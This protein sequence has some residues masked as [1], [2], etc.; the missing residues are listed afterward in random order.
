MKEGDMVSKSVC[1][2]TF[3]LPEILVGNG[4]SSVSMYRGNFKVREKKVSWIPLN[5][6]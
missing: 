2:R 1:G 3:V 5:V 4:E 6:S